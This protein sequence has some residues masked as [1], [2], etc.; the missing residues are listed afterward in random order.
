[1]EL[2]PAIYIMSMILLIV[3]EVMATVWNRPGFTKVRGQINFTRAEPTTFVRSTTFD[4]RTLY[5]YLFAV[6]I[7]RSIL[8]IINM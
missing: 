6:N 3:A 4:D 7:S 8:F 1:M 2:V 5:S